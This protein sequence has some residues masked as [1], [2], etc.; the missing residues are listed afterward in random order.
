M[1]EEEQ[2][3]RPQQQQDLN[4]GPH[5]PS[6]RAPTRPLS[7]ILDVNNDRMVR[8]FRCDG[9]RREVWGD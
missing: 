5:C 2:Q 8:L 3:L 7:S 4:A 6:C 9:C 1:A